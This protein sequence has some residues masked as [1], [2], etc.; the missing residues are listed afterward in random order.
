M[1]RLTF[2]SNATTMRIQKYICMLL[3]LLGVIAQDSR[4]AIMVLEEF[5]GGANGWADRDGVMSDSW[6]GGNL[7]M[8]GSFG[9]QAFP[10]PQTDAFRIN[11]GTDFLGNYTTPGLTQIRFDLYAEDVL[12][13]DL[14]IRLVNGSDVFSYQFNL[15]SMI[16]DD[17]TTF[18]VN[19]DWTYGWSGPS[20][21]AFN[22]AL[23]AGG[24]DQL[25]IQLTRNGT[26]GQSFYL[27]NVET[28]D[29]DIGGGGGNGVVPEPNQAL[30]MVM[31]VVVIYSMRRSVLKRA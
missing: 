18:T 2:P 25:E 1:G 6:D 11:S 9:S 31:G 17:W 27:D 28:L 22:T 30:L 5:N 14:F 4:G 7:W 20:Q 21:S 12:P 8:V 29:T 15:G 24:V 13:S 3:L 16:I 19:L 26:G 10:I 23:G